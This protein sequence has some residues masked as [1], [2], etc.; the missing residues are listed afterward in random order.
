MF[1]WKA[2]VG[3]DVKGSPLSSVVTNRQIRIRR[4]VK[5]RKPFQQSTP[6]RA[7]LAA[8][9]RTGLSFPP[10]IFTTDINACWH[11]QEGRRRRTLEMRVVGI[12]SKR[13][14]IGQRRLSL[15]HT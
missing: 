6:W 9:G 8:I 13:S 14:G 11:E 5:T 3:A 10:E 15:C 2:V 12:Q 1:G 7:L 4:L